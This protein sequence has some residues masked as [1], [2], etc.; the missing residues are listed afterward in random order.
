VKYDSVNKARTL[1]GAVFTITDSSGRVIGNSNGRFTTNPQGQILISKLP[2][3]VYIATEI[4]APPGYKLDGTPQTIEI[5]AGEGLF[6]LSFYNEPMGGL[7]ILKIDEETRQPIPNVEFAVAR[8]NGERLSANTYITDAR[9]I[10]RIY[11]LDDGWYTVTEVKA[12]KGYILDATPHSIEVK[13]GAATPLRLTNQKAASLMIKKTDSVSGKGIY[14]VAFILYDSGKNPIMQLI[15][16]QNGIAFVDGGLAAG[17]YFLRE[18]EPAEGYET[19][20]EWKTIYLEAGKTT[21]VEWRNKPITAQIQIIK[22]SSDY[23]SVTGAPAGS[24]LAGAVFEI[25]RARSGVVVG[26]ITTDARGVAASEPLPLGRYFLKEVAAPQYYQLSGER[27]EAELAYPGQIVKLSAYNKSASLGAEIKKVGNIEI[28]AGDSMR[29]DITVKNT[30]NVPLSNFYWSDRLPTD[31]SRAQLITTGTY[32]Q[33]LY[34]R[35]VYKTDYSGWRL[36]ASNL[37]STNNY[38]FNLS[39]AALGLM[40]GETVT[41][42]RYEFGTVAAGFA[43]VIKSTVT[44]QTLPALASGYQIINRAE[45]GGQYGGAPQVSTT[46]WATKVVRFG[47]VPTLPKTGS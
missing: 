39:A 36:L 31:A 18:L 11:G 15:T 43:T 47:L 29:Y 38:S 9:G 42:I 3:G 27:M 20:D 37:L 13:N 16:D 7:E 22:Y 33:R 30:S 8:M 5:D 4:S 46:A 24:T 45:V 26:Y 1:A 6:S 21:H 17:R 41:N 14:G 25:T 34:Y 32:N 44:V 10:I 23:N 28:I 40:G 35:S 12:A 19:D 2:P